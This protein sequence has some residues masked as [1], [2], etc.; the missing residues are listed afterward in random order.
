MRH[1]HLV[2]E[3]PCRGCRAYTDAENAWLAWQV[4]RAD[5][6]RARVARATCAPLRRDPW[7]GRRP[8]LWAEPLSAHGHD[9]EAE[10]MALTVIES[11]NGQRG[12]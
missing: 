3:C 9:I 4:Q 12:Q 10:G 8:V 11:L 1:A 2:S 5:D 6:R 7:A